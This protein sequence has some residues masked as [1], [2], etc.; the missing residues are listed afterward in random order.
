MYNYNRVLIIGT[1][2]SNINLRETTIGTPVTNFTVTTID[3]W[4]NRNDEIKTHKKWHNVV[5]WGKIAKYVTNTFQFGDEVLIMGS[6]SYRTYKKDKKIIKI[7]EIKV[8]NIL[9]WEGSLNKIIM[10]GNIGDDLKLNKITSNI[11]V[12]NF[13]MST[14]DNWKNKSDKIVTHEK[15]HN[16]VCWG[17]T[18]D[19]A[20][21]QIKPK[22]LILAEGSISYRTENNTDRITELKISQLTPIKE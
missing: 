7:T 14:I 13:S 2:E 5:C 12:A 15:L 19:K 8:S 6:I 4:K 10:I 1:I 16:V 3:K 21:Q 18:A 20:S 22:S 9:P 17:K 11:N